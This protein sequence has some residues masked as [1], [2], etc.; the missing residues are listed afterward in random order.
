MKYLTNTQWRRNT[1]VVVTA[2]LNP[3][4][5]YS[6]IGRRFEISRQRVHQILRREKRR[7][8]VILGE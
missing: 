7:V 1:D 6:Q 3:K 8:Q 4:L 5:S 2:W